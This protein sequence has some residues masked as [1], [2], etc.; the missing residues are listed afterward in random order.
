MS[1]PFSTGCGGDIG[2]VLLS[3]VTTFQ[4][5][6]YKAKRLAAGRRP[7]TVTRR[8]MLLKAI[9]SKAVEWQAARRLAGK[10]GPAA[11]KRRGSARGFS[12]WTSSGRY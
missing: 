12:P 5:E 7:G 4:I 10:G 3:E 6:Q 9:L 8:M 2:G 11:R 1:R